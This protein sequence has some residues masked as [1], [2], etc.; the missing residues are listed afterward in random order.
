MAAMAG[1]DRLV[2]LYGKSGPSPRNT[3]QDIK[4]CPQGASCTRA[5]ADPTATYLQTGSERV[6]R[7]IYGLTQL[8]T[9]KDIQTAFGGV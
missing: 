2:R 4:R 8:S 9:M 7:R 3:I 5:L 1:I 6:E